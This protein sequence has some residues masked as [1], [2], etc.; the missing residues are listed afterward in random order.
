[1][2][3]SKLPRKNVDYA[4]ILTKKA[5]EYKPDDEKEAEKAAA[6]AAATG[7]VSPAVVPDSAQLSSIDYQPLLRSFNANAQKIHWVHWNSDGSL[8]RERERER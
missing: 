6:A 2:L 7:S 4:K 8:Q 3:Y 1:M 5:K